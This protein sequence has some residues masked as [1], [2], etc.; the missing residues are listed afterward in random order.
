MK[1]LLLIHI[2]ILFALALNAQIIYSPNQHIEYHPG[3]IPII[4][5]APHGGAVAPS[6]IPDRTCNNPTT[7]TDS[8]T[9]E[10]ALAIDSIFHAKTGCRIHLIICNL[11]RTKLDCNRDLVDGACGDPNAEIAWTA[12][13]HYIDS[14]RML[15]ESNFPE[16]FYIDLHAHGHTKQR[17]ELG[18][19]L[20]GSRLRNSDSTLNTPQFIGYSSIQNMV[21]SNANNY[22]HAELLRGPFAL[23]T[24]FEN[25]GY[26]AVPSMQDIHPDTTDAFFSGGYNTVQ[27]TCKTPGVSSNGVQIETNYTGIRDNQAN[28]NKFADS[29]SNILIFYL[30]HHFNMD[31][32][33][34]AP[35]AVQEF[36][37]S[38]FKIYP[39]ILSQGQKIF[40]ENI[41]PSSRYQVFNTLGEPIQEGRVDGGIYLNNGIPS[42][43]YFLR[44]RENDIVLNF[45]LLIR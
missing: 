19:L 20:W 23:G 38:K 17:L 27:H 44:I 29:L 32:S 3:N 30:N 18:Y 15:A 1:R 22:S 9:R 43:I 41:H 33:L 36:S 11:K 12:F 34:C 7:V 42:G 14:S 16:S 40:T 37:K 28:I 8:K 6:N 25:A 5:S 10:M 31:L 13:Q 2:L 35:L 26:P 45:K 21:A 4:L 24:L 39:S